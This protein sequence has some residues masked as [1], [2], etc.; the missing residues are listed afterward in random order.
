MNPKSAICKICSNLNDPV[1][2]HEAREMMFGLHDSFLYFQ[3][4]QCDCLQIAQLPDDL[5]KYYPSDYYSFSSYSGKRFKGLNGLLYKLR[6][7]STLYRKGF[8]QRVIHLVNPVSKLAIFHNLVT[9]ETKILDVGCGNGD[10]FLYPLR[11]AGLKNVMGCDPFLPKDIEYKNGLTL[12]KRDIFKMNGQWDIIVYNHSFE[13]IP[14]PLENLIKVNELLTP[15]GVCI[16]RIPTVP[17][18]AWSTYG[19]NWAQLDAPRHLFLH[20]PKSIAY[21]A[22][23]AGLTLKKIVYDS[24]FFQF[25]GSEAIA[26][27]IPLLQMKK[28]ESDSFFVRKFKK[29]KYNR[30]AKKLNREGRGDQAAFYLT[31][32]T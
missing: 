2:W 4:H 10:M 29:M 18:F 6:I 32:K 21:L 26:K 15:G 3:C 28:K 30:L 24:T 9:A 25:T 11:E 1:E 14:N 20:S 19:T 5:S 31:R 27:G 7:K 13:H 16:I 17:N 23:Q 8:I 12:Y 22:D